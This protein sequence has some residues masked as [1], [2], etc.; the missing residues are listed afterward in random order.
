MT[1]LQQLQDGQTALAASMETLSRLV[2]SKMEPAVA[3]DEYKFPSNLFPIKVMGQLDELETLLSE[4]IPASSSL[5]T[6]ALN[7]RLFFKYHPSD[8]H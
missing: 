8:E 7:S 5:V 6:F 2:L 1:K 3:A 4:S